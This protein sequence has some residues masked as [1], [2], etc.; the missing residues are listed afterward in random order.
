VKVADP[1][2]ELRIRG[3]SISRDKALLIRRLEGKLALET[4]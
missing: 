4:N 3:A 1:K 2:K